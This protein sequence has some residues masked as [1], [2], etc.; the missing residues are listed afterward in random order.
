MPSS[1][2]RQPAAEIEVTPEMVEAGVEVFCAFDRR[3]D[4]EDDVVK[5]IFRV[6]VG[7]MYK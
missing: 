4:S 7:A 3:F 2:K 6:M 5:E 1:E